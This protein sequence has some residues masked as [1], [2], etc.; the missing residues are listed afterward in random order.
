MLF[1]V[2]NENIKNKMEKKMQKKKILFV[3]IFSEKKMIKLNNFLFPQIPAFY[4]IYI[5]LTAF[6]KFSENL[7]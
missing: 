2:N 7:L 4:V 5:Y 6:L 3:K 1:E